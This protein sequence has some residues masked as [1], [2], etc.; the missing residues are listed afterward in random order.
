MRGVHKAE[1][2]KTGKAEDPGVAGKV[3]VFPSGCMVAMVAA[4][5]QLAESRRRSGKQ[6]TQE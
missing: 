1:K 5:E 3:A 6:K 4:L 2:Q